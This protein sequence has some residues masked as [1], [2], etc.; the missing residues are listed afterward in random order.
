M[1]DAR[2]VT[3]GVRHTIAP[4]LF[5][6]I[7]LLPTQIIS[8]V[9]LSEFYYVQCIHY[10]PQFPFGRKLNAAIQKMSAKRSPL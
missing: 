4:D 10:N 3:L 1:C 6:E 5:S 7:Y 9:D 2:P 8:V